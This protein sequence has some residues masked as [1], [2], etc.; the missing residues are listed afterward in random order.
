MEEME[1]ALSFELELLDPHPARD[2]ML[3]PVFCSGACGNCSFC[4]A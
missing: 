2:T 3:E 4:M 1:T